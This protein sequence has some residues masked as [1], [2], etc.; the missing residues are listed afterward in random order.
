MDGEVAAAADPSAFGVC[1]KYNARVLVC[2]RACVCVA[3]GGVGVGVG[4]GVGGVGSVE[5]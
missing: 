4:V 2:V 1:V 3:F 5:V